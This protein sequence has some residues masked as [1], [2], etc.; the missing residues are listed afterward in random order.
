MSPAHF[1]REKGQHHKF[2][3]SSEAEASPKW[4][5]AVASIEVLQL[6]AN[7]VLN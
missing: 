7:I 3:Y 5:M 1:L 4:F 6:R 2:R